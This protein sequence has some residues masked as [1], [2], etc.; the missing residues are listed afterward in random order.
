MIVYLGMKMAL[1]LL[2]MRNY[3]YHRIADSSRLQPTILRLLQPRSRSFLLP[4]FW[5]FFIRDIKNEGKNSR[6]LPTVWR[7]KLLMY[8]KV[9]L[10]GKISFLEIRVCTIDLFRSGHVG[11]KKE[12]VRD[13]VVLMGDD[14]R[15]WAEVERILKRDSRLQANSVIENGEGTFILKILDVG[16]ISKIFY[17]LSSINLIRIRSLE[18]ARNN[19]KRWT[20]PRSSICFTGF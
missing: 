18:M 14:P 3:R 15:Y 6:S 7:K 11:I 8:Y 4:G 9:M 12:S 20:L 19:N 5:V 2:K 13:Q 10:P 17:D 16:V 1:S